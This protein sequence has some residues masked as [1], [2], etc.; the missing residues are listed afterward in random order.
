[1]GKPMTKAEISLVA[2]TLHQAF[3]RSQSL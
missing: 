3:F 1:M 2:A